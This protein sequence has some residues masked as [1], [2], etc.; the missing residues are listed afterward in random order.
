METTQTKWTLGYQVTA[1]VWWGDD[2]AVVVQIDTDFEPDLANFRV[3]LND[4]TIFG[5]TP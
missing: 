1:D 3:N 4:E 2:G 5:E